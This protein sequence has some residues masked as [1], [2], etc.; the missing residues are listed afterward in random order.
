MAEITPPLSPRPTLGLCVITK[1]WTP[2]LLSKLY[3][4]R[5]YF[6]Q[7][8]VQVNGHPKPK[9]SGVSWVNFSFYKWNDN[10][11]DARNALQ[12]EVTTDYWTWMDTDDILRNPQTLG[13]IVQQMH[14]LGTDMV[15][16]PYEYNTTGGVVSELQ[17]RERIIRTSL[18]GAWH[19]AIHETWI[20]ETDAVRETNH[21][22]V[23]VHETDSEH[24]H[25]SMKRNRRILEAEA[26]HPP[27][28]PRIWYY[29]G[30]NYGMDK[31]YTEAIECF[32]RLIDSSGWD[33]EIYRS[34]LQI[35]S[36]YFELKS[37]ESAEMAAFRAMAIL[38]DWPDAYFMLQ[39]LYYQVDDHEKALEWYKVGASKPEPK[40]DSAFNPIVRHYQPKELAA[41]SYLATNHP[42]D[43][44]R[45]ARSLPTS[46]PI[47]QEL[48]DEIIRALNEAA[49]ITATKTLLD[50]PG[51]DKQG[52]L[53]AL[54]PE[55]R[56]DIRLTEERR[57][58]IPGKKWPKGS[59]VFYC[60]PS[61]EAWGPDTL[62]QGMGGSEEAVVYLSRELAKEGRKVVVYNERGNTSTYG[63]EVK[64]RPWTEINPNDEFDVFVAWRSPA[65]IENIKARRK[66]LDLHDIISSEAV[67]QALPHIDKVLF[68]SQ[69]HRSLYP[70]VPDEK[71]VVIGN[72]I[73]REHFE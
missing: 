48:K 50:F 9:G 47:R 20:P 55:L 46:Y 33:E 34:W 10:F 52:V 37:Y 60:G 6:D 27:V 1:E 69:F 38:P 56:S 13:P 17:F 40:S 8:Y 72:G 67:Y 4:L 42:T 25:D 61:F 19:G 16:A 24:F 36:C 11:A 2:E 3:G 63:D 39:Q 68:K 70:G 71:A 30:L 45:I 15:F 5:D 29:L 53:Q 41:Y 62:G 43:A 51:T 7:L 35:F 12:Q 22:V 28:D 44:Y 26:A 18:A 14:D 64:Y 57:R 31:H 32:E 59:I 49:A 73:V 58:Y 21:A 54:P 65:G 23:W 66:V